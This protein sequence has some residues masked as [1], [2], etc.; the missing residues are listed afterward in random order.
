MGPRRSTKDEFRE[1]LNASSI[2]ANNMTAWRMHCFDPLPEEIKLDLEET[3]AGLKAVII[4][5]KNEGMNKNQS[6]HIKGSYIYIYIYSSD[7]F[8]YLSTSLSIGLYIYIY[9]LI[10]IH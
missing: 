6:A 3:W 9:P 7:S 1:F 10:S 5:I 4:N 8:Y 2:A